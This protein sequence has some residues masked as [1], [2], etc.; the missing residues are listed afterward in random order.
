[1]MAFAT[2]V[3]QSRKHLAHGLLVKLNAFPPLARFS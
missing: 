2:P 3:L 1:M